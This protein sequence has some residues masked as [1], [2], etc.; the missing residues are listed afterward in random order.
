[1]NYSNVPCEVIERE[2]PF[3][4]QQYGFLPDTGGV[5][6]Y[7]GGVSV[8]KDYRIES[9]GEIEVQWRQDR[10]LYEPWGLHGGGP[11]GFAK[12]YQISPDGKMRVLKKQTFFAN[13]GDILRA[14]I[15]AAGGWGN[16]YERD[17]EKVLLDVKNE[18]VSIEAARRDYGVA[19]DEKTLELDL[20]ATNK[21]RS[22]KK[23]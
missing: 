6:K 9:P 5:G 1:L 15:P 2:Y 20:E 8:I 4:L 19:I 16:P 12:G 3:S 14:V 23:C 18:L 13:P 17:P 10:A 7:R 21:L 22:A 11:G